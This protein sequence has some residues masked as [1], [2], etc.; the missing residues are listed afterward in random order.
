MWEADGAA[1]LRAAL[2]K[3]PAGGMYVGARGLTYGRKSQEEGLETE[4]SL[5]LPFKTK[6]KK[7]T[8]L[9]FNNGGIQ[10]GG[11]KELRLFLRKL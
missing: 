3:L 8:P 2:C 1:H 5:Q 7:N 9:H 6:R 4:A 11:L 10:E